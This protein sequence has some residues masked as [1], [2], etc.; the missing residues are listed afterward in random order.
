MIRVA[1]QG[2]KLNTMIRSLKFPRYCIVARCTSIKLYVETAL[3][4]EL[5]PA[6]LAGELRLVLITGNAGDGKT[7]FLQRFEAQA[8]Q[9]GAQMDERQANGSR[10][11]LDGR[12]YWINYDGS[13]DEGSRQN[14]A[15]L[16]GYFEP[17]GGADPSA[18]PDGETRLIAINEGRLVDFLTGERTRFPLLGELVQRGLTTG[19]PKHGIAVVNLNLRSV[20]A[21]AVAGDGWSI[22]TSDAEGSAAERRRMRSHAERG[23]ET[24]AAG[25]ILERLL[26]RMV[27]PSLW[28]PC[29]HCDLRESCHVLHNVRTLQDETAGPKVMERLQTLYALTH[30]RGRL[31]ITLRDLGSALSFML[32]GTRNCAEIHQLYAAGRR[33]DIAQGYYFNSWMGGSAP[34]QEVLLTTTGHDF[35]RIQRRDDGRLEMDRLMEP[36][37]VAP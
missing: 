18:W 24:G 25:S 17:F 7:A 15:V 34:Y 8:A 1:I 4:R 6:V 22:S 11:A 16:R 12:G 35:F 9:R 32:A 36:G 3:D 31:H 37:V 20:V 10:F 13:Q 28:Q 21:A 33:N 30:L 19:A 5:T 27:H 29:E 2:A 14:D 23:N 26:R